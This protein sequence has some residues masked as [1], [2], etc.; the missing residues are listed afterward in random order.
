LPPAPLTVPVPTCQMT[1]SASTVRTAYAKVKPNF[2]ETNL[3]QVAVDVQ[4]VRS[5]RQQSAK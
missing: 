5:N 2:G 4:V 3:T 1:V